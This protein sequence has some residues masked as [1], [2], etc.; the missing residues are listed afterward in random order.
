MMLYNLCN[1]L[2][3]SCNLHRLIE[4]DAKMERIEIRF[5]FRFLVKLP[6]GLQ[7]IRLRSNNTVIRLQC[8]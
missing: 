8:T 4:F 2:I 1:G 3:R 6:I 5:Y 7:S